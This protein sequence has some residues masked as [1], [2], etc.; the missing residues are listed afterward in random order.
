[1]VTVGVVFESKVSILTLR[2]DLCVAMDSGKLSRKAHILIRNGRIVGCS[3]Q[4]YLKFRIEIA[5]IG[6]VCLFFRCHVVSRC[7]AALCA[8]QGK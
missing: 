8:S 6:F 7:A 5:Q 3:F 4:D 2:G 1:M